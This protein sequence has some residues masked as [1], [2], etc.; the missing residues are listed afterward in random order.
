MLKFGQQMTVAALWSA[1]AVFLAVAA[2]AVVADSAVL[3]KGARISQATAPT[4]P[5]PVI[6][7]ADGPVRVRDPYLLRADLFMRMLVSG[8][9]GG[10]CQC[11]SRHSV[12]C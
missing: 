4:A 12:W 10:R 7:T 2:P 6:Q 8:P 1:C 3:A 11:I 5:T 9:G